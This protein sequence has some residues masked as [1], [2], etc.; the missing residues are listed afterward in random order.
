MVNHRVL[1]VAAL[2][3]ALG[4]GTF[5][6]SLAFAHGGDS[7]AVRAAAPAAI[8]V[9]PECA[10]PA[11]VL[12]ESH[13]VNR[14]V[15]VKGLARATLAG[16][17]VVVEALVHDKRLG[18]AVTGK[19]GLD[20][21]FSASLPLPAP[22]LR[23]PARYRASVGTQRSVQLRLVRKMLV[24][25]RTKTAGGTKVSGRIS[26]VPRRWQLEIR[27]LRCTG[28]DRVKTIKTKSDGRFSV[29]FTKP[30]PTDPV[31]LYRASASVGGKETYTEIL[32]AVVPPVKHPLVATDDAVTTREDTPLEFDAATLLSNDSD[33]GGGTLSVTGV[34]GGGDAHGKVALGGG[35]VTYEPARDFHGRARFRY[36]LS[37]GHSNTAEATVVVDVQPVQDPPSAVDDRASTALNVP[38]AIVGS[39]L[40]AND[41]DPDGDTLSITRVNS[42]SGT[43]GTVA[44]AG[45]AVTF[46]PL[47]GFAGESPFAYTIADGHGNTD[48][49]TVNVTVQPGKDPP[50]RRRRQDRDARGRAAGRRGRRPARKRQR[51][52]WR[53]VVGH[54]RHGRP[55]HARSR[56][57]ERRPRDVRPGR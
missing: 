30:S 5:G 54:R 17:P 57:V 51:S 27:R 44:L 12:L 56:R 15:V 19:V 49:A 9:A 11:V 37:D 18:K 8:A 52:R 20:G 22:A 10:I 6:M 36:T 48:D 31:T 32:L 35:A 45:G 29:L 34:S 3:T 28:R 47:Q 25:S 33:P 39:Q 53:R 14:R 2:T 16:R 42:A 41:S 55:G 26:G 46:T 50:D 40:L 13:R 21:K 38:L 1:A 24:Q 43:R 4:A 23:R 7:H